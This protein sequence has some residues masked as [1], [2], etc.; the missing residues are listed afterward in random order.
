MVTIRFMSGDRNKQTYW[1][2]EQNEF[3]L[4]LD[5]D[6]A[7]PLYLTDFENVEVFSPR[8]NLDYESQTVRLTMVDGTQYMAQVTPEMLDVL[9]RYL[10]DKTQY[11]SDC[12]PPCPRTRT[13]FWPILLR[14]TILALLTAFITIYAFLKAY[15]R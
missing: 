3:G 10:A 2:Y 9:L 11:P 15:Y 12:M 7:K 4:P 13:F 14:R 1:Y 5:R 6:D 8:H